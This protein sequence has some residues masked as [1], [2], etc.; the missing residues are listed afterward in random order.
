MRKTIT[1]LFIA[2]FLLTLS[3]TL[4]NKNLS[5]SSES[6]QYL[7]A[8]VGETYK[9]AGINYHC[10][11]SGSFVLY[12]TNKSLTQAN[13]KKV[14]PTETEFEKPTL[15]TDANT[16]FLKRFVC[17]AQLTD[18]LPNT[19]YYYKV[20]AGSEESAIQS[21]KTSTLD[22]TKKSVLLLADIHTASSAYADT[23]QATINKVLNAEKANNL[24]AIV[25]AG[26]N[27]DRGGY[28]SQWKAF[29]GGITSLKDYLWATIPGN[30]EYYHDNQPG[31]ISP[32]YY[33]QF[34]YNPQNGPE[35]K[36][37]SSYFF[38][39]GNVLFIMLD[40]IKKDN[41]AEQ[42]AWFKQVVENNPSTWIIVVSH[43]G[44]YS[45]GA[46]IHDAEWVNA[47]WRKTFE[48]CQVDL[49]LSGHEHLYL[50]KDISYNNEK[51]EELGTTYLV[52]PSSGMKQYSAQDKY[53]DQ[54]DKIIGIYNYAANVIT[55][56]GSQMIVKLYSSDGKIA[57][58]FKLIAKRPSSVEEKT[59]EEILNSINLTYDKDA[60]KVTFSWDEN[61]WGNIKNIQIKCDKY[62]NDTWKSVISSPKNN[63][64]SISGF[65]D[66][67]DYVFTLTLTKV[68][69]TQISKE[70][71]LI[72]VV[73]VEPEPTPTPE[74]EQPKKGCKKKSL[75]L[76]ISLTSVFSLLF[77]LLRKKH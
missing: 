52:V 5:A 37:N 67:Y 77:V 65:Y 24:R 76:I 25:T 8:S 9:T 35:V 38:K 14:L 19:T 13:G 59:D 66:T 50:R 6:I 64:Y 40:I 75:N 72:N 60:S 74:P 22:S 3:F 32:E 31:Y 73:E 2:L 18:L 48:E 10:N 49:A 57:E 1:K 16:G 68:D 45:C 39:Y 4:V 28:E 70:M 29:F 53:K 55:F 61:L 33:N 51:N 63:S 42:I 71:E 30:H 26:D 7:G 12:G 44:A 43:P 36:M 47:N 58:E 54:F 41:N 23:S 17:K 20:V 11:Q 21:F 62:A 69:D 56:N 34:F 27:I 46:Y 15:K